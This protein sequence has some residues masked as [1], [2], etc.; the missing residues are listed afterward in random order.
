MG[1]SLRDLARIFSQFY[2][3]PDGR[4]AE[5]QTRAGWGTFE[6]LG[7]ILNIPSTDIPFMNFI[8]GSN[9]MHAERALNMA[10]V[11]FIAVH[12][13]STP[14]TMG[15]KLRELQQTHT[16]TTLMFPLQVY[17]QGLRAWRSKV[18]RWSANG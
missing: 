9:N 7:K 3:G 8:R 14:M 15:Q 6:R 2:M 1:G 17:D 12:E 13:F 4:W 16:A 11:L 18:R 5:F 10:Y